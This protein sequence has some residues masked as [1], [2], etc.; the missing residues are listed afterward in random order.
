MVVEIKKGVVY[1]S[2]LFLIVMIAACSKS[3]EEN[4]GNEITAQAISKIYRACRID[5]DS[6]C[7]SQCCEIKEGCNGQSGYRE[8][9]LERGE[10]KDYIYSDGKCETVCENNTD[11]EEPKNICAEGW[12]CKDFY[13]KSFQASNCSL[14]GEEYCERGCINNSCKTACKPNELTCGTDSLRICSS[15]GSQWLT[16]DYCPYGCKDNKCLD[17]M[18]QQ[19]QTTNSNETANQTQN[20]TQPVQNVCDSSCFSITNFHYDAAGNDCQIANL[21]DEYIVFKNNCGFSCDLTGWVISDSASHDYEFPSFS[22]SSQGT[23]SLYSGAGTNTDSQLYWNSPYT[24]CKAI[25]NNDA[26]A[27]YLKNSNNEVVFSYSYP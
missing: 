23:F 13:H 5:E 7:D 18:T 26:D 2:L 1:Y 11:A 16:Q 12:V 9:D 17:S 25:W 19:N 20:S 10:W 3:P 14:S 15:D 8:C 6:F 21:N 27:L 4:L 24:P 22:I